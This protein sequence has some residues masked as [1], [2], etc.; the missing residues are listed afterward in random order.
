MDLVRGLEGLLRVLR[1][2]GG[3]ASAAELFRVGESYGVCMAGTLE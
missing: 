1:A 2:V 3:L